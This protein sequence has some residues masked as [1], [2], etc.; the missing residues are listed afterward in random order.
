LRVHGPLLVTAMS[1]VA[2]DGHVRYSFGVSTYLYRLRGM[3]V[4][5]VSADTFS[6]ARYMVQ[7]VVVDEQGLPVE[8]AALRIGRE[9]AFT[10]S[11]G[12]FLVRF[13]K[14]GPFALSVAPEEFLTNAVY[15]PVSAPTEVRAEADGVANE[16]QVTVRR[17]A[18]L[19]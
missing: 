5:A 13:S 17:R 1:N 10:D 2:P 18:A 15:E 4:N 11:S 14:H 6:I 8:G 9:I 16:I 3:A 7:G 19:K 12:H